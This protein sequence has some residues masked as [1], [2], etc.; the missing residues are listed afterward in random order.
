[1]PRELYLVTA[2]PVILEALVAAAAE[3]DEGLGI[4]AL[5]GGAAAQLV[6]SDDQAVLTIDSSRLLEDSFDAGRV[7]EGLEVPDG[8]LWWTEASAPWGSAGDPG[9]A[10]MRGLA[11][12][13]GGRL[14]IEDG[15]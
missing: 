4:R 3:V 14:K 5:Y 6:A 10:V 2:Q 1:V 8:P 13:C 12:I 15:T 9:V 11:R 7:T